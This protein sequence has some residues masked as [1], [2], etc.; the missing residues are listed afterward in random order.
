MTNLL[1]YC[2]IV[3]QS[4]KRLVGQAVKT[5][6]SHAENM[7]SIPVRVTKKST[8]QLGGVLFLCLARG[9]SP[10]DVRRWVRIRHAERVELARKRQVSVY[11]SMMKFPYL[12]AARDL[13]AIIVPPHTNCTLICS[14]GNIPLS[15]Y[16]PYSIIPM[17]TFLW[18]PFC[19]VATSSESNTLKRFAFESGS[20]HC[21][22]ASA[23]EA[24]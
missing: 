2:I 6:A 18:C 5:S 4:K 23:S 7:G 3:K 10:G 19:F 12:F 8:T 14:L 11:S 22:V 16:A 20:K 13:Y 24:L 9:I 15:R 21:S 17:D 1:F